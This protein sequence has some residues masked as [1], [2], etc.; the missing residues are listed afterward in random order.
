[1]SLATFLQSIRAHVLKGIGASGDSPEKLYAPKTLRDSKDKSAVEFSVRIMGV[2]SAE[3]HEAWLTVW[4]RDRD[5]TDRIETVL[6]SLDE[7]E[8]AGDRQSGERLFRKRGSPVVFGF[9]DDGTATM[10]H[11]ETGRAHPF[12]SAK[13]RELITG[14]WNEMTFLLT[15]P[16][17]EAPSAR[18]EKPPSAAADAW[19]DASSR[20]DTAL[21]DL[22]VE[23]GY[24]T[25]Q[26]I[27]EAL[28]IQHKLREE[29]G[30]D[31]PLVQVLV[32]KHWLSA[33]Q[34]QELRA[35]AAVQTGEARL[36]AG[37]EA[38]SKLGQG[39]MGAVYK[40]RRVG[41]EEFVALKVLPPSL[42]DKAMIARFQRESEI[43]RKLEHR[44]IVGCIEFGFDKR[45]K[46]YFC[47]LELVDGENLAQ[48]IGRQGRLSEHEALAIT[49]QTTGAL[50]HAFF[51]GL[52]H[53]DVKPENIMV[54]PNG[55][56][57]LLDLGLARPASQEATRLTES[58][59]FI[60][61]PY[62]ASPEQ[63]LGQKEVDIRA[64][65]YSLGATL[66]HMVTG[67]PPFEATTP[68]AIL[69]KHLTEQ[70]PWPAEVNPDL[71]DGLCQI[72]ARMMEKSPED[73]YQTPNDLNRDLDLLMEGE[74]PEA[75]D[76]VLKN[77][78]VKV[79]AVRRRR[80]ERPA[81]G[82]RI[83]RKRARDAG[84]HSERERGEAD[85]S[86]DRRGPAAAGEGR[87][88][89]SSG[90]KIVMAAVVIGLGGAI[91]LLLLLGGPPR[92]RRDPVVSGGEITDGAAG[93][94][95]PSAP[96]EG[97]AGSTKTTTASRRLKE[98]KAML[99]PSF[100]DY[101]EGRRV[102]QKFLA[103][104]RDAP[105]ARE[106]KSLLVKMDAGMAREAEAVV[107]RAEAK[108]SALASEGRFDEARRAVE[109]ARRSFDETDALRKR[110]DLRI[111]LAVARI[112]ASR[113]AFALAAIARA[114]EALTGGSLAEARSALATRAQWSDE[115]RRIAE[116]VLATVTR[117]EAEAAKESSRQVAWRR[118]LV[119]LHRAGKKDVRAA[120]EVLARE[121]AALREAGLG[122]KLARFEKLVRE[123]ELVDELIVMGLGMS[124]K[125]LR[126]RWKGRTVA[127]RATGVDE[128][129]LKLKPAVGAVMRIPLAEILPEEL[130]GLSGVAKPESPEFTA[131]GGNR[132][133]VVAY[134]AL[135]GE[136]EAARKRLADV[137][138]KE[139]L[140]L[141]EDIDE[142]ARALA[143]P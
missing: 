62:Y 15:R 103:E 21:G 123:A 121:G 12:G 94:S 42:A 138:G 63:A 36:V 106:A 83:S 9:G 35:A 93:T 19:G 98:I 134:L 33:D 26:Q 116:S 117:A 111:P 49:R 27:D 130:L 54:T 77:S 34:A 119:G 74:V 23:R 129:V 136:Y 61:S 69:Q 52:V 29:M 115:E 110:G 45:R 37:Y 44:N 120:S 143:P 125:M 2:V 131:A 128:R 64:D 68:L 22:A 109:S 48:H 92:R 142:L 5:Q 73:R 11:T 114:R 96:G 59:I 60:G 24:L 79:P 127:G 43:V 124:K 67:K 10:I 141:R 78:S 70:L 39:G 100:K 55:T 91:G 81:S 66:Y 82:A 8:E 107:R 113:R 122:Q 17:P 13:Y 20:T 47:A 7:W 31:Q 99:D 18:P 57:K 89:V 139:A 76:V 75:A 140:A 16:V 3:G 108:A 97:A 71:S 105:E 126:L 25:R 40:A 132:L 4:T 104:F 112:E 90:L 30:V 56:A 86:H 53:R 28:D 50:Q 46:C 14:L 51:N 101:A 32:G 118:F 72:I 80:R 85:A 133:R 95:G 41:T 88:P 135:R 137:A 6:G 84:G 65:I 38:I 58:G 102:L 1:M 87:S